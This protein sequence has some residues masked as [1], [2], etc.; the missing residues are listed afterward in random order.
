[1]GIDV[2]VS[3]GAFRIVALP[4]PVHVVFRCLSAHARALSHISFLKPSF[5]LY[6]H[7]TPHAQGLRES[8]PPHI[9]MIHTSSIG[10]IA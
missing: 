4:A 7:L 8:W 1:M 9:L 2:A 6:L 3:E 10:Y 5:H